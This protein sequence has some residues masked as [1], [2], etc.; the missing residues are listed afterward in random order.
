MKITILQDRLRNG[1]T[2]RQSLFLLE[3]FQEMGHEAELLVFCPG[4]HLMEVATLIDAPV[5]FLQAK[6][7]RIAFYAPRL[8][9]E[10]R[11]FEPDVIMCMG[12]NANNY[13]GWLQVRYPKA[14]VISTLR[15]GKSLLPTQ[16]WSLKKV[17]GVM[18]NCYWWGE[19][20]LSNGFQVDKLFVVRNSLLLQANNTPDYRREQI[21]KEHNIVNNTCVFLN[22]ATFRTGKRHL[23]LI[24]H[25]DALRQKNPKLD[26]Q[27]W[28][29]G[30][31]PQLKSV[32][33]QVSRLGLENH[34]HF[35]G[36]QADP[37]KYYCGADVAVSASK[38][39]SLPNFLIEAQALGLPTV[40]YA[41]RGVEECCLPGHT[42]IIVQ[43]EQPTDFIHAIEVLAQQ[44][45]LRQTLA[46]AA[47][48]FARERF[49][50]RKQAQAIL[51]VFETLRQRHFGNA[52]IQTVA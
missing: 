46:S 15:T 42:G 33:T 2:E 17:R 47:P 21:R 10:I 4:G 50:P 1:G 25:F 5:R 30:D 35:F 12:S 31:G 8:L 37:Y 29:V 27:L 32:K 16:L 19:K 48:D 43:P 11:R 14:N 36:Y 34:I 41:C 38:E 51:D 40:A 9:R 7:T 23:E 28:L 44:P 52:N 6:D 3:A 13:A 22:V 24:K 20:L 49:A 45:R 39:D 26:W 18:V